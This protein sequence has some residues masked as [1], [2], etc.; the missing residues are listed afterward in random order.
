MHQFGSIGTPCVILSGVEG[1]T[2]IRAPDRVRV[3]PMDYN[4]EFV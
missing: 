1:G 2:S 3:I 4:G